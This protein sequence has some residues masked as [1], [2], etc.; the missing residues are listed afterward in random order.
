MTTAEK[1]DHSIAVRE[2]ELADLKRKRQEERHREIAA[3]LRS[4]L[5]RLIEDEGLPVLDILTRTLAS[6]R[7]HYNE[8]P[9]RALAADMSVSPPEL[10]LGQGAIDFADRLAEIIDCH[11]GQ[12]PTRRP[13]KS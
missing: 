5:R 2:Q 7:A 9:G 12:D 11:R 3:K 8:D 10:T 6:W 1:L 4:D 13:D